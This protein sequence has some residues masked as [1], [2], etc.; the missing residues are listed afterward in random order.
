M[1]SST[2]YYNISIHYSQSVTASHAD[3]G[4]KDKPRALALGPWGPWTEGR[5]RTSASERRAEPVCKSSAVNFR[6]TA[7]R[8]TLRGGVVI[9]TRLQGTEEAWSRDLVSTWTQ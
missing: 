5:G 9:K 1:R 6:L 3:R 2:T 8:A 4:M 7:D